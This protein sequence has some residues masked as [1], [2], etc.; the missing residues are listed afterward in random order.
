VTGTGSDR[1]STAGAATGRNVAALLAR[2]WRLRTSGAE[3]VPGDGPVILASN[4]PAFLDGLFLVAAAPR[5]VHVLVS[6]DAFVP[7]FS[8]ALTASGAIRVSSGAPDRR[9]LLSAVGALD[10]G[11]VVGVF[12]EPERGAGDVRHVDHAA[13]YLAARTG[14]PVVPVAVLGARPVGSGRDSLPR[15]R[16]RIDVVFGSP[17]DI[18]V[19][20]DVR[21]RAVLARSGERLRQVL[22]DH[23]RTACARTGQT[24]PGP[25]PDTDTLHRSDS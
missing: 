13:A 3:L 8:H 19:E 9:A 21:R 7:P 2:A 24:L 11:G 14:A 5:P 20:G 1:P 4:H 15:L 25:L 16:A 12:A 18:R 23:V 6:S 10:D 22:A 17:L